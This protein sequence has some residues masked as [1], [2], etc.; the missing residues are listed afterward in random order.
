MQKTDRSAAAQAR[1]AAA[2]YLK[3]FGAKPGLWITAL[4]LIVAI[5]LGLA[6]LLKPSADFSENENR[7]PASFPKLTLSA[8]ADGSFAD[9]VGDWFSDRFAG[10]DFWIRL[11]LGFRRVTGQKENGGVWLGRGGQLFLIPSAPNDAAMQKNLKA[12]NEFGPEVNRYA[13]IVPNACQIL[14]DRLPRHA[15]APDQAAILARIRDALPNVTLIDP[16]AKLTEH[17]DEYIFYKSDHHWTSL[18]AFYGFEALDETMH[19]GVTAEYEHRTVSDSFSGTLAS[20]SGKF[21]SKD[22][23]DVYTPKS[24]VK[25]SVTYAQDMR[26][27][28]S[29]Y[30]RSALDGKDHYTV[31]FGGNHP[32]VDIVSTADTG[33][34]LLLFKDSYANCVIQFLYPYFERIVMVDPRY[35]YD[36]AADLLTQNE[37][38]DVLYL[39]NLDTFCT[40]TTLADALT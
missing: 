27:T 5:A 25:Y 32:R 17:R 14:S 39:Y 29:M 8:L 24:D 33:R 34:R 12:M 31:F 4:T 36:H 37:I 16:T 19:F 2:G 6:T 10:R 26:K 23:V 30:E 21:A 20:K 15:P 3:R 35:Y 18:G 13:M 1:E 38:T 11:N 28:A 22:V 40:D 7:K 9:G